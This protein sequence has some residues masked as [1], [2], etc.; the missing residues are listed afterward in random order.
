MY[1][2]LWVEIYTEDSWSSINDIRDHF[3]KVAMLDSEF[4]FKEG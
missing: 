4:F 2:V 1:F 3:Y